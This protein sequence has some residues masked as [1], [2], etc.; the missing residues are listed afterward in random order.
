MVLSFLV[1]AM[2]LLSMR[3][4]AGLAKKSEACRLETLAISPSVQ[5]PRAFSPSLLSFRKGR[6]QESEGLGTPHMCVSLIS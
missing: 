3:Q 2:A 6:E 4:R 5:L 1:L